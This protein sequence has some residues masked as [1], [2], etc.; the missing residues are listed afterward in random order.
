MS[1]GFIIKELSLTSYSKEKA[2]IKFHE[3]L[4]VIVGPSN[5]GKTFIFQCINYMFGSSTQP[6]KIKEARN[7]NSIYLEII[8][9]NKN[10]YTLKSDL[11]GGNILLFKK[12]LKNISPN[13]KDC[14]VLKRTHNENQDNTISAFLLKLNNLYGKKIRKNAKGKTKSLSYRDVVS[15]LLINEKDIITEDSLIQ[16]RGRTNVTIDLNVFKLII[17]GKDDSNIVEQLDK[18]QVNNRK[19]RI[20]ILT[21]LIKDLNEEIPNEY[22][23]AKVEI[24]QE[25][26]EKIDNSFKSLNIKFKTIQ[27]TFHKHENKRNSLTSKSNELKSKLKILEELYDRSLILKEQYT[28]DIKRLKSSIEASILLID[29]NHTYDKDCPVCNNK[30]TEKCNETEIKN[31]IKSCESEIIKI[32]KLKLELKNSQILMESDRTELK[33]KISDID[34]K[35]EEITENLEKGIG[36]EMNRIYQITQNL[37]IKRNNLKYILK[38]KSDINK[39]SGKTIELNDDIK[40]ANKKTNYDDI[41][42]ISMTKFLKR[43]KKVLNGINLPNLTSVTYNKNKVDFSISGEDRGLSGKGVRAIIYASFIIAIQE[44]LENKPYK[45]SIPVLDSP[46]VT[47]KKPEAGEEGIT[48][49]MAMDFYRYL[50]KSKKLTQTIILENEEPPLDIVNKINYI[51]FGNSTNS[52]RKGFIPN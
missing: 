44:Y 31:I 14:E 26:I 21:D 6:K 9:L 45:L 19:G 7:Y 39:Y 32:E 33:I 48:E 47:Y 27:K 24:L 2:S 10:I 8:D 4:N 13:D 5:C 29:N 22:H 20:Q 40:Q 35:I 52:L 36:D 37:I 30:I 17:S 11:K 23:N 3:G 34:K 1:F 16:T 42:D 46:L 28:T 15:F 18:Q 43:F 38:L 50:S 51:K 49:D 41:N 12:K 25:Q